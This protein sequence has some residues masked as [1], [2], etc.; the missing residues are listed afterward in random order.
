M[1]KVKKTVKK[2]A[3]RG[4]RKQ[5]RR[6][7]TNVPERASCSETTLYSNTFVTN[8]MYQAYNINLTQ[9]PRASAI[10]AN[11]QYYRIKSVR[12][13]FKPLMDTFVEGGVTV[14]YLHYLVDK[15]GT[16]AALT[17]ADQLRQTGAKPL[18]LDDKNIVVRYSPAV[19]RGVLDGQPSI[20]FKQSD[21]K[22]SPWLTTNEQ[23]T[24]NAPWKASS[25]DH[26][27][28]IFLVQVTAGELGYSVER[29]VEFE[30][31]KALIIGA[32]LGP[33]P[34]SI[35]EDKE[36]PELLSKSLVVQETVTA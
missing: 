17:T 21:Y 29:T 36:T 13:V 31:K 10:A 8:Q 25:I 15:G 11:Y 35:D 23:N 5:M 2:G 4:G 33:A 18:R 16:A 1:A 34:I 22:V 28:L 14:P 30:F 27:G 26:L 20:A 24:L 7:A 6:R 9:C 3:K 12:F 32:A 19:L